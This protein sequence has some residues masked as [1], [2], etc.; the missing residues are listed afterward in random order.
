LISVTDGYVGIHSP[1][2]EGGRPGAEA[3]A[4]S[5]AEAEISI[6]EEIAGRISHGTTAERLG[7]GEVLVRYSFRG[8][9]VSGGHALRALQLLM[10]HLATRTDYRTAVLRV[11]P[12]DADSLAVAAAAGFTRGALADGSYT[13]SRPVPPLTYTDGVITIRRQRTDDLDRHLEGIDDEQID[14]LWEPGDRPKWEA[15]TPG[16]QRAGNLAH[17]QAVHDAFGSGPKWTFSADSTDAQYVAYVDCDLA[18]NHVPAGQ[19]NIAYTGHPDHRGHGNVSRAV[20]LIM[21]FLRDHTGAESAHIIVDAANAASLR[22][23]RAVGARETERW[24]DEHG[25]TMIRH[26]LTLR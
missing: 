8:R 4:E 17:L 11:Q 24:V 25:R 1:P 7:T 14:W 10:H 3:S 23:A 20:R 6:G 13:L 22:V 19:A 21:A 5:G 16:Q 2:E 18:N 15:L 26:V 12:G 9:P